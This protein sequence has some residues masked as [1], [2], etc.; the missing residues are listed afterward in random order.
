MDQRFVQWQNFRPVRR[1]GQPW[2]ESNPD[3]GQHRLVR[4]VQQPSQGRQNQQQPQRRGG[5][6]G[7]RAAE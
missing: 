7:K 3:S 5:C 2:N 4:P 1:T 6:C